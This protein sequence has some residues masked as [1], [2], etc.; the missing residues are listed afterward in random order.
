MPVKIDEKTLERVREYFSKLEN[1]VR[2]Y[3]AIPEG[4]SKYGTLVRELLEILDGLS[5]KVTAIEMSKKF[6][7]EHEIDKRPAIV[8][9][10]KKEYNIRYFG[11]PMGYEFGVLIEDIVYASKGVPDLPQEIISKISSIDRRVHIQVFVTPSCPYCPI[12]AK[13]SH[14]YAIANLNIVADVIEVMEFPSLADKYKVYAV[15][16]VVINDEIEFEGAVPHEFFVEK[17]VESLS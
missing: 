14:M 6:I 3:Y 5:E 4:G 8:I 9:H 2:I 15:P 16:K 7:E 10:G 1:N 13:A 17:I 12:M 11:V